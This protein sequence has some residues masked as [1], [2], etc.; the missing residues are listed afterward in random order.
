MFLIRIIRAPASVAGSAHGSEASTAPVPPGCAPEST[1]RAPGRPVGSADTRL[2]RSFRHHLDLPSPEEA[3]VESHGSLH[4][5]LIRELDISEPLGVSVELVAEY[6]DPVN[7][8]APVEMLLQLLGSRAVVNVPD[9]H[10]LVVNLHL[11][12][13]GEVQVSCGRE[14]YGELFIDLHLHLSELL[15]LLLHGLHASLDALQLGVFNLDRLVPLPANL[16]L[17]VQLL[18]YVEFIRFCHYFIL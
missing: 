17:I 18:V 8:A 14:R 2:V 15:C 9:V 1:P 3:V 4:G 12:L 5:V 10:G 6:G 7:G 13:E 16:C 11:L